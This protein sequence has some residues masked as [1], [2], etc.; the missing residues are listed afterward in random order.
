ME[1]ENNMFK[2]IEDLSLPH[3]A[4][5]YLY[6]VNYNNNNKEQFSYLH[7]NK[8]I[9][10][11]LFDYFFNTNETDET[12]KTEKIHVKNKKYTRKLKKSKKKTTRKNN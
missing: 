11:E 5:P 8:Y 4:V 1:L 7:D 6:F 10:D 9:K 3:L 2:T 12:I